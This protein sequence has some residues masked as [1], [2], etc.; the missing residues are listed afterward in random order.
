MTTCET[1]S[2]R[3]SLGKIP[4]PGSAGNA[5]KDQENAH[6]EETALASFHRSAKEGNDNPYDYH[7]SAAD[8]QTGAPRGTVGS[9]R[10][11]PR[12]HRAYEQ[13]EKQ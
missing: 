11:E 7:C 1:L 10:Q 9:Y 8:P 5:G 12:T 3:A 13:S 6:K 2:M 4:C